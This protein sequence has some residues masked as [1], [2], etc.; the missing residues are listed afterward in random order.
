MEWK[1]KWTPFVLV[2]AAILLI[3]LLGAQKSVDTA[4]YAGT[5]SGEVLEF[6]EGQASQVAKLEGVVHRIKFDS[7]NTYASREF[8]GEYYVTRIND[9]GVKSWSF[10]GEPHGFAVRDG[11]IF[12]ALEDKNKI[13]RF[14]TKT[15]KIVA[16]YS[17]GQKPH[18]AI[19]AGEK[20]VTGNSDGTLTFIED[21]LTTNLKIG[22]WVG[23]M[24]YELGKLYVASRKKVADGPSYARHNV[25]KG[26]IQVVKD[27]EVVS[28][29]ALGITIV[30]HGVERIGPDTVAVSDL[31][32]GGLL[33]ANTTSRSVQRVEFKGN[34]TPHTTDIVQSNGKL[35]V[36]DSRRETVYQV[37]KGNWTVEDRIKVENLHMITS[38]SKECLVNKTAYVVNI[39]SN[40]MSVIDLCNGVEKKRVG[41]GS[42]PHGMVVKD[43][44]MYVSNYFENYTN[45]FNLSTL[46]E[47]D[48]AYVR[49][50]PH[51]GLTLEND[52]LI[53][54]ASPHEEG[55]VAL[56][57]SNNEIAYVEKTP[58][59]AERIEYGNGKFFLAGIRHGPTKP[60]IEVL[61]GKKM[62]K[63][64][65]LDYSPHDI[66]FFNGKLYVTQ[67]HGPYLK[68]YNQEM[69]LVD[70]IQLTQPT[71]KK[72][73]HGQLGNEIAVHGDKMFVSI[74][75]R[76]RIAVVRNGEVKRKYW[77]PS[78]EDLRVDEKYVYAVSRNED[79]LGIIDR[80]SGEILQSY[81][82]GKSPH[83][84]TLR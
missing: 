27:G 13:L 82:T 35:Y 18:F 22:T 62:L 32:N 38:A 76:N 19:E 56:N 33:V 43:G 10:T 41:L 12:A 15:E 3:L 36:A 59:H 68:V 73:Y 48:R 42:E 55:I 83:E 72:W 79:I 25:T 74:P 20:V 52:P 9:S 54:L 81:P 37:E 53:Y 21:N 65:Y 75:M 34:K 63:L 45:V 11:E 1:K 61:D 8:N 77:F 71:E 6:K 47:I 4:F 24:D 46:K 14:D 2:G 64:K 39:R 31:A 29:M 5:S 67:R 16:T 50:M 23:G 57:S 60:G 28:K 66:A 49:F 80:E 7:G 84:I 51:E 26:Y 58:L 78:P 17:T 30:P 44:K 69:E 40:D 70:S